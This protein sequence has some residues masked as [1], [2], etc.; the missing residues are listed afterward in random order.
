VP[1][2]CAI[3][4]VRVIQSR[5]THTGG[6]PRIVEALSWFARVGGGLVYPELLVGAG[7]P[8]SSA[9]YRGLGSSRHNQ[10][11]D[12]PHRILHSLEIV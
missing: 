11:Y 7:A 10:W 5:A 4:G 1:P 12:L 3:P 9:F 6:P 2:P 8:P